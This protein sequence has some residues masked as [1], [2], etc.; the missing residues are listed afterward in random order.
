MRGDQPTSPME[1]WLSPRS[2][3]CRGNARST[4]CRRSGAWPGLLL[5]GCCAVLTGLTHSARAA[6]TEAWVQRYNNPVSNSTLAAFAIVSD[7]AGDIIVAGSTDEGNNG[8]DMLTI[9]YS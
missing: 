6:V 9:K 8:P 7:A 5:A 3:A 2:Q 4:F 1:M